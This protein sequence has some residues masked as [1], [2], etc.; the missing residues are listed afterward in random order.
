MEDRNANLIDLW[1]MWHKPPLPEGTELHSKTSMPARSKARS[2]K[3]LQHA[4]DFFP[5]RAVE[6]AQQTSVDSKAEEAAR[7]MPLTSTP[8]PGSNLTPLCLRTNNISTRP[9]SQSR[10]RNPWHN[11]RD[12]RNVRICGTC[13]RV[14]KIPPLAR[15]RNT[16]THLQELRTKD[17]PTILL[18]RKEFRG[19]SATTMRIRGPE[20]PNFAGPDIKRPSR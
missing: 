11:S 19:K 16:C 5:K 18:L 12:S 6:S 3:R 8:A 9:G 14:G 1:L 20:C 4:G 10:V 17:V 15:T 13:S 7:R 2:A